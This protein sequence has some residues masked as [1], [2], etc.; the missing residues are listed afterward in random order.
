[1]SVE[2]LMVFDS[3]VCSSLLRIFVLKIFQSSYFALRSCK[4]KSEIQ[5]MSLRKVKCYELAVGCHDLPMFDKISI[6]SSV[7]I[8]L[9][10][11]FVEPFDGWIEVLVSLVNSCSSLTHLV[12]SDNGLLHD[13]FFMNI[14][15]VVWERLTIVELMGC[16]QL[17]ANAMELIAPRCINVHTLVMTHC[18][19]VSIKFD[20]LL[21][22]MPSLSKITLQQTNKIGENSTL[23]TLLEYNKRLTE[24]TVYNAGE[25]SILERLVIYA[26]HY[27]PHLN[28]LEVG[29]SQWKVFFQLIKKENKKLSLVLK[30]WPYSRLFVPH[31]C[32]VLPITHMVLINFSANL[33][34]T[35]YGLIAQHLRACLTELDIVASFTR[36]RTITLMRTMFEVCS[37]LVSFKFNTKCL[38]ISRIFTEVELS[39]IIARC[40]L[41]VDSSITLIN[42]SLLKTASY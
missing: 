28:Y 30:H 23:G 8:K 27:L 39:S 26:V 24:V 7:I 40:G 33:V 18:H 37:K 42:P 38:K 2:D 25:N 20:T 16:T 35:I 31:I 29:V 13:Q 3:A 19:Y 32:K 41:W 6:N 36:K 17:S 9:E 15:A 34:G 22:A 1:M 11:Y 10:I 12:V 14:H 4:I 21:L 5:W